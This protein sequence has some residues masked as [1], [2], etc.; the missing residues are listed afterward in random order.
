M[1]IRGVTFYKAEE[2][3]YE[4]EAKNE[5]GKGKNSKSNST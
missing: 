2:E 5:K 4:E 1:V 3:S